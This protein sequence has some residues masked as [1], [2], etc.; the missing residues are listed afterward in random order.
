MKCEA[1]LRDFSQRIYVGHARVRLRCGRAYVRIRCGH[2]YV[3]IRSE[4]VSDI[5][6][7]VFSFN[8]LLLGHARDTGH[9]ADAVVRQVLFLRKKFIIQVFMKY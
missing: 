6:P 8:I 5:Y 7:R 4:H 1:R 9:T 3:R 2:A